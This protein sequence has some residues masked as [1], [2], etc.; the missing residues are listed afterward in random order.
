M[1]DFEKIDGPLGVPV[2]YQRLPVNTVSVSWIVF[3]GSADDEAGGGE[4]IYHW[5]EHLPSRGTEKFPG[6]YRDTEAR[7]VRHGGDA[8]AETGHEH[9][10]FSANVPKRVWADALD[11]LSDMIARP[12]FRTAD[13]EAE[14]E[15]ILQEID[16]WHSSPS[17][18]AMCELPRVLWPGHPLGHDQLGSAKSLRAIDPADLQRAHLL[19]YSRNRTSLFVAGNIERS[20]LM[21]VIAPFCERI[22]HRPLSPRERPASYGALPIWKSGQTTTIDTSFDDSVVYLLFPI[23]TAA[24]EITRWDFLRDVFSAGSLGSPL[25]QLVREESQLAYSPDFVSNMHTD[26]GFAGFV[27]QTSNEPERVLD[28]F[29]KL[30]RSPDIRSHEWL[31]YVRDTIRGSIE[32]HDPDA[33]E[34]TSEGSASL[35]HYGQM[36]SDDQYAKT[37]LGYESEKIVDWLDQLQPDQAHAIVFR[38]GR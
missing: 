13:I 10:A 2:Y 19:G 30:I 14:R 15:V 16:E 26:G 35:I 12:L 17:S 7:L 11:V 38:G 37:L 6:G 36:I 33:G 21:D 1:I 20:E 8:D 32:M 23:A 24:S 28:A 5:F 25:C 22:P 27:A 29:W 34:Y 18:Y 9:T 4:G 3:V 31:D